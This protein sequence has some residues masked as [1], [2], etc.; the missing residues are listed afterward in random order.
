MWMP[1]LDSEL[2]NPAA[3]E[4]VG[5]NPTPDLAALQLQF[6]SFPSSAFGN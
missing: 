1:Q 6:A 3:I 4:V 2:F 5:I